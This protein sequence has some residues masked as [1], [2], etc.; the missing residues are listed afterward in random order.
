MLESLKRLLL[1]QKGHGTIRQF[2][3]ELEKNP[4]DRSSFTPIL[5]VSPKRKSHNIIEEDSQIISKRTK[6]S[7]DVFDDCPPALESVSYKCS[8]NPTTA[9]AQ[10]LNL[11]VAFYGKDILEGFKEC[12]NYG[13]LAPPIPDYICN[14]TRTGQNT[15]L[16]DQFPT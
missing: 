12:V 11:S 8:P 2:H 14:I 15:F 13:L 6:I 4:L 7:K 3:S 1:E 5:E 9:I 16:L 10:D